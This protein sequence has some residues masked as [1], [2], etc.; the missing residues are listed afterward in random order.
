M[1]Y[2][3]YQ[4]DAD[5]NFMDWNFVKDKFNFADYNKVYSGKLIDNGTIKSETQIL[6]D[7]YEMFNI[8]HPN[9][10]HARSLSIS[11]IV[12][13]E[14]EGGIRYYYCNFLGWELIFFE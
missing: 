10:Y 1:N 2:Y 13:I 6:E 14:R 11:D 12:A 8:N 7:I 3:I 4:T 9:D 5:Y